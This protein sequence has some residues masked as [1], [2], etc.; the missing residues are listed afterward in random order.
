V[1]KAGTGQHTIQLGNGNDILID[2]SASLNEASD[3]TT[4]ERTNRLR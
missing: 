3:R 2:G 4:L 1:S